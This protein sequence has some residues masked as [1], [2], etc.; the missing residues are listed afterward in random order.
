MGSK[1]IVKV[2]LA[3]GVV[4]LLTGSLGATD[5]GMKIGIVDLDQA[6]SST[7]EGKAAR[8]E[9]ERKSR[10]AESSLQPMIE[11]YQEMAK[12]FESKQFVLSDDARFQKQLDLKELRDEIENKQK[13]LQGQ[14]EVARERLVNPLRTKLG[15]IVEDLGRDDGFSLIMMRNTPGLIYT[16]EALDITDK[17]IA[18]FNEEG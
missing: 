17:V 4:A 16:R 8:E 6:V 13:Q 14:L 12:E 5:S 9:L 15:S 11:R 10:E 18:K 2:L 3:I 7:K 1:T